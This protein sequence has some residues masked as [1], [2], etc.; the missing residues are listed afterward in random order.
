[1]E[2]TTLQHLDREWEV[3]ILGQQHEDRRVRFRSSDAQDPQT[4]EARMDAEE[5]EDPDPTERELALRRA[6]EAS[7]VLHALEGQQ[8][9]LT[10]EEVAR[11]TGMPREA[12]EDR[13]EV[14]DSVQPVLES[15]PPRR[16]RILVVD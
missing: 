14:L 6:L 7:L 12:V 2:R 16:Y 4:F 5:V 1:M 10:A 9:G 8:D 11:M 13:F 3:S 15:G